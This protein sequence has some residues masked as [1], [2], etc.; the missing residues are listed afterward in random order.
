M[1]AITQ[2][3]TQQLAGAASRQIAA[4]LGISESTANM[5]VQIAV[6]LVVAALARNAS[7]PQGSQQLHQAIAEDHDGSI[8]DNLSG[9][10]QNPE[11]AN[12]AG[13]LGHVLGDQRS[14]VENNVAQAT[15]M[16]QSSA[17][18]LMEIVAP[19]VM[20]A[21]GKTQQQNGLD[22]SGLAGYLGEQQQEQAATPGIMGMVN[23]MLDSNQDGSVTDD[24]ARMAGGLFNK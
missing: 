10:L 5:A 21:L 4:R 22:P 11:Q 9:Y 3:I 6:P 15:G 13:I 19:L 2:M 16:D 20:G 7:N 24:L 1:N 14:S 8:L 23:S 12:G 17:G 18:S